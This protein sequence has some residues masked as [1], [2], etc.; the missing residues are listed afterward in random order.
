[1]TVGWRGTK[2]HCEEEE[3]LKKKLH[4]KRANSTS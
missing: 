3:I 1:M 4:Q 2:A